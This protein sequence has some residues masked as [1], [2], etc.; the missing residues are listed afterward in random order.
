M[1]LGL[2]EV[3]AAPLRAVRG[4]DEV[5]REA[6]VQLLAAE[7]FLGSFSLRARVPG[8][9]DHAMEPRALVPRHRLGAE[10][11][12]ARHEPRRPRLAEGEGERGTAPGSPQR[13]GLVRRRGRATPRRGRRLGGNAGACSP[14]GAR[15]APPWEHG[16]RETKNRLESAA[17]WRCGRPA[18][19]MDAARTPAARSP[20]AGGSVGGGRRRTTRWPADGSRLSNAGD[21]GSPALSSSTAS[22]RHGKDRATERRIHEKGAT[23]HPYLVRQMSDVG[24]RPNP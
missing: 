12:E 18:A 10:V 23:A 21:E 13:R 17:E 24:F 9:A 14:R 22:V 15:P 6:R 4:L 16:V 8:V 20:P 19:P 3:R 7:G 1:E 11:V 2:D 5:A